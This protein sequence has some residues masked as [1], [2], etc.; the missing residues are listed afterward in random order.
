[1]PA[2]PFFDDPGEELA[3]T[4]SA[5]PILAQLEKLELTENRLTVRKHHF[6]TGEQ[7]ADAPGALERQNGSHRMPQDEREA[8][9]ATNET[10]E[11]PTPS[12]WRQFLRLDAS[13]PHTLGQIATDW[14][15]RDLEALD[16][17]WSHACGHN[18]ERPPVRM[19]WLERP[20]G[21]SKTTDLAAQVSYALLH[22]LRSLRG[23]AI[24]ADIEQAQLL[25]AAVA[26][27]AAANREE[28]EPLQIGRN[29]IENHAT[30][31][32]L[33]LLGRDVAS[34][35]G[36]TP[37]FLILDEL[38]HWPAS[39]ES[40]WHSLTSSAA[41]RPHCVT[42]IA[43][44]AGTARNWQWRLRETARRNPAWHF[45]SLDGPQAPWLSAEDLALQRT[46]LPPRTFARLWLNQ[47]QGIGPT[48]ATRYQA[49]AVLGWNPRRTFARLAAGVTQW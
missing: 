21:H 22:S 2:H 4:S 15:R 39:S 48:E 16:A 47:W 19:A 41:K 36:L 8:L 32:V 1:M 6:S 9:D 18:D 27:L 37:D 25:T 40:L 20:R 7:L 34:S 42:I 38:T 14:Q 44:N 46:L 23:Y 43:T 33:Q 31:S 28:F 26:N 45:T 3:P 12:E 5:P 35:Y 29:R 30:G 17:A 13:Q 49:G 11:K 10:S 24:A